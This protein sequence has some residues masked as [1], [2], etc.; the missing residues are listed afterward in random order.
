MLKMFG[1]VIVKY[2]NN[3]DSLNSR[4]VPQWLDL[5]RNNYEAKIVRLP[6]REEID[7][8]VEEHLIVELYSK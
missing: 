1:G 3:W 7:L 8:E 2:E 6:G 4:P 5:D